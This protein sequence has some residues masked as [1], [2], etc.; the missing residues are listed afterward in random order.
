MHMRF[1]VNLKNLFACSL[2]CGV[3]IANVHG[4]NNPLAQMDLEDLME[5]NVT[6]VS[7]REQ[8]LSKT[9][10]AIHIITQEDI[11]RSGAVTVA[12]VLDLAPGVQAD[13]SSRILWSVA[14]RGM[15]AL[16]SDKLL[17]MLDGRSVY[18][19]LA[20]GVNWENVLPSLNEIERIEIIRGPGTSTWGANAI[21]GVI[22][23]ITYDSELTTSTRTA[24]GAGNEE[25]IFTRLRQGGRNGN[26]TGR[27][28][29][30]YRNV[31][32]GFDPELNSD[33]NDPF[34]TQQISSRLDW[35]PQPSDAISWDFGYTKASLH[36]DTDLDPVIEPLTVTTKNFGSD[37]AWFMN[38]WL[39]E[40]DNSDSIQLKWYLD[41]E[42]R[43]E[44]TYG[45]RQSTRDLDFQY[46]VSPIGK[47]LWTIGAASRQ[48]HTKTEGTFALSFSENSLQFDR[49]TGFL[50]DEII[51][52]DSTT[53]TLG[54]KYEDNKHVK[55]EF[56]PSIRIGYSFDDSALIWAA[57]SRAAKTPGRIDGVINFKT[58]TS[59]EIKALLESIESG[60]SEFTYIETIG[61]KDFKSEKANIYELGLRSHFN[62]FLFFDFSAYYTRYSE[63]RNNTLIGLT[64][65]SFHPGYHKI[66]VSFENNG[67]GEATGAE[68]LVQYQ[69]LNNWRLKTA[70]T[71]TSLKSRDTIPGDD[72]YVYIFSFTAKN[73]AYVISQFDYDDAWEF[74]L[75]LSYTG[76]KEIQTIDSDTLPSYYD[77]SARLGHQITNNVS[78]SLICMQLLEGKQTEWVNTFDG[79]PVTEI[80]RSIFLQ[81]DWR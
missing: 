61:N 44:P 55:P 71:R 41:W 64:E 32:A 40:L 20:G 54:A 53:L 48:I 59:D 37:K 68:M 6:T 22:N 4:A 39:H 74:D 5:M 34:S 13:R 45:Y 80:E 75:K 60:L 65:D 69:P 1:L 10:A 35:K 16:Y 27:I 38:T 33:A 23:I 3:L 57:W 8:S 70:Y 76:K 43:I 30:D 50:Q 49:Y 29:V 36:G 51:F 78:L 79:Y 15:R 58:G 46:N 73:S 14:S 24:V 31:N 67:S 56:Q 72:Y 63:L 28:N 19:P 2:G 77:L 9:A 12:E 7:K 18:N 66:I 26:L 81:I 62:E 21:N 17:V 52:T 47:H 42:D 25:K 11:R